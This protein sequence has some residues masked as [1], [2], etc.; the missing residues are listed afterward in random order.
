[1]KNARSVRMLAFAFWAQ[2]RRQER[3]AQATG[4]APVPA[5]EKVRWLETVIVP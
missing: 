2:R 4:K 1:L 3:V 5:E